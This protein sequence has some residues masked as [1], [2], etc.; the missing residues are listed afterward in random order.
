MIGEVAPSALALRAAWERHRAGEDAPLRALLRDMDWDGGAAL[1]EEDPTAVFA[2]ALRLLEETAALRAEL[3]GEARRR[4]EAR[5]E[6]RREAL[7]R[8]VRA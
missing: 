4:A 8:E 5:R 1:L 2:L 3:R 6:E 7:R